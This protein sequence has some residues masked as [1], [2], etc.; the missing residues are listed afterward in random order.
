MPWGV[1]PMPTRL[2]RTIAIAAGLCAGFPAIAEAQLY[3]WRD[4]SGSLVVSNQP[5]T[6]AVRTYAVINAPSTI[7]TTR[8][9][10]SRRAQAFDPWILENATIHQVRPELVRAV[11]QAESAFNPMATSHKGA[12]GLMQLMPGTA[13][14]LGVTDPFDPS[15]N[16][17]G[18]TKY[19]RQLLDRF[20]DNVELALAAYNAGPG[21]VERY[22]GVP[23]YRETRNYVAK[24][25][26]K[27]KDVK[28]VTR[29]GLTIYQ[30]TE[31]TPDGREVVRYTDKKPEA[32]GTPVQLRAR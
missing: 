20:D 14:D 31:L 13:K 16:I 22:D 4:A 23:P 25:G 19:L 5:R 21:A 11:I 7:K 15:D 12:M 3:T 18:G 2:V 6:G 8:P 30:V 9:A 24:I 1:W 17:R 27:I 29:G 10:L 26:N 32:G 28:A